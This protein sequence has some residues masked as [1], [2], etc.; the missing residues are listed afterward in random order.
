MPQ[1]DF[2]QRDSHR[3]GSAPLKSHLDSNPVK[4]TAQVEVPR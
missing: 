2:L 1:C 3:S 4:S